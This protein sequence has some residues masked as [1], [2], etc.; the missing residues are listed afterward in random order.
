MFY[1]EKVFRRY[2]QDQSLFVALTEHAHCRFWSALSAFAGPE[3]WLSIMIPVLII[4]IAAIG[5]NHPDGILCLVSLDSAALAVMGLFLA[6]L[7]LARGFKLYTFIVFASGYYCCGRGY[8]GLQ[9]FALK[10]IFSSSSFGERFSSV[11]VTLAFLGLLIYFR[12]P[13]RPEACSGMQGRSFVLG[14]PRSRS[15]SYLLSCRNLVRG[16]VGQSW[17]AI[18]DMDIT[19]DLL[20][21]A[22][23]S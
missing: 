13:R 6:S 14:R 12:R 2:R 7:I 19:A 5:L 8:F 18:R 21:S 4:L 11:V 15:P 23:S 9:V 17:I 16:R 3:Y 20:A 1:R 10:V 22:F